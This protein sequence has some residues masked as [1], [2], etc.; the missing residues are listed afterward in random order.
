[1]D[2]TGVQKVTL[3]S[4]QMLRC[5]RCCAYT[6]KASNN[7]LNF[8]YQIL[9]YRNCYTLEIIFFF[10]SKSRIF[11]FET[12]QCFGLFTGRVVTPD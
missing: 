4:V 6:F 7:P 2:F 9:G 3:A 5:I 11:V 12:N 8:T 1:M 10:R